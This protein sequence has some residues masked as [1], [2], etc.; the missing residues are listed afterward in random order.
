M[1]LPN[2]TTP[3]PSRASSEG[4]L[5]EAVFAGRRKAINLLGIG[6]WVL[7]LA[8]FWLWWLQPEH[9]ASTGRYIVITIVLLWVTLIPAYFIFI[10]ANARIPAGSGVLPSDWRVAIIVTKTP[11]EPFSL[12]RKTLGGAL[13]QRDIG[14]DTWLADEDPAPETLEWCRKHGVRVSSRKD[15]PDYHRQS[16][17][18][19]TRCK[20]GNLAYF[21]DHFGY[22]QYDFVSQFDADHVPSPDYL[23]HALAPFADPAVGYVSAPSICDANADKSWS[24]RGRLYAEASLHGALQSGYNSGWAP[25]CIG[26]HYTVRTAA[27]RAVGGLGPELAEDH[28]TALLMNSG[29]WRGVH[30]VNAIAHGEG[31]E[32]FADLAVQEFQWSRSLMTILLQYMPRYISGLHGRIRFQFLFSELWYPM[33]SGM[34]ATMFFMP[35][36]ALATGRHFA[37]VTY[38]DFQIHILPLSLTLLVLAYWWRSTGLFRPGDAKILSWEGVAFLFLRWPWALSGSLAA[39]WDRLSGKVVDFRITPKGVAHTDSLP[40]R[41]TTPYV[42]LAL[43]SAFTAWHVEDPGTA[44][45]FYIFNLITAALYGLLT[46]LVLYRHARENGLPVIPRS[47]LGLCR[48]LTLVLIALTIFGAAFVNGPKGLAAMNEGIAAFTLTKTV[49]APAGAGAGK[50]GR[51]IIRFEPKWHGFDDG[52]PND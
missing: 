2:Q 35:I 39:V 48:A 17:P 5:F 14:H 22:E 4:S 10:F 20:E 50:P 27:L 23:R 12:V 24:A 7:S 3:D 41:V 16:W 28:S 9:I 13:A 46:L 8:Y 18:R 36:L 15:V 37:N 45:G 32:T 30:A 33:F 1:G 43:I 26:S 38:I 51:Q 11:S 19:R 40:Y 25:L 44:G 42:V 34:M 6:V 31:P 21:Y 47:L 29:G 49:Y 52:T